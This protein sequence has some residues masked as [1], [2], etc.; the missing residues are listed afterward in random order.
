MTEDE[1]ETA[2]WPA[3]D[4]TLKI[5]FTSGTR[6]KFNCFH[7]RADDARRFSSAFEEYE[8]GGSRRGFLHVSTINGM[9]V[10]INLAHVVICHILWDIPGDR[11]IPE[12]CEGVKI[13]LAGTVIPFEAACDDPEE[14]SKLLFWAE[15]EG[16]MGNDIL[17]FSDEDG[18]T[19]MLN[20]H[21]VTYIQVTSEQYDEGLRIE[22]ELEKAD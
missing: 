1:Q 3:G 4:Y 7:V 8:Q 15:T 16:G 20:R 2:G 5:I 14:I 13:G 9:E 19:V 21:S 18:E 12:G 6:D 10:V 17:I 22:E 11:S